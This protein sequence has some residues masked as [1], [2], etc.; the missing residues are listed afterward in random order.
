L[1]TETKKNVFVFVSSGEN[2]VPEQKI[3]T[4]EDHEKRRAASRTQSQLQRPDGV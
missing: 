3:K 1:S 2:L 4:K